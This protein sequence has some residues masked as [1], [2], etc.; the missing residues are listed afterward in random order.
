MSSS[1]TKAL[2]A[3]LLLAGLILQPGCS[4]DAIDPATLDNDQDGV[5]VGEGDCDDDDGR[6]F[7]GQTQFFD[8]ARANGSFDFDC[9]D[10]AS[11]QYPNLGQCGVA[12]DACETNAVDGWTGGIVPA[13]GDSAFWLNGCTC[14]IGC[15]QTPP[16]CSEIAPNETR[17]QGC[18]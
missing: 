5:T 10:S 18:R 8:T 9:D 6:V 16:R 1:R 15:F 14:D 17:V 2:F 3:I 4:D 12:P 11:L 7:P 13:C